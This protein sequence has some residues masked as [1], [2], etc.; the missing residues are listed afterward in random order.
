MV[1]RRID[2]SEEHPPVEVAIFYGRK[3]LSGVSQY[4]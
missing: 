3:Y 1:L 2:V 4:P